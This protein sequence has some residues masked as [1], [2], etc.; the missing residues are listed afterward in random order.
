M[1]NKTPQGHQRSK[2]YIKR[3]KKNNIIKS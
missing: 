3:I 1:W 2:K